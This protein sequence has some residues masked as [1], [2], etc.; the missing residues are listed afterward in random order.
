MCWTLRV[1][2]F[3]F[4]SKMEY[5]C[6]DRVESYVCMVQNQKSNHQI[7]T[8]GLC[9]N[10]FSHIVT[11]IV[12]A[13]IFVHRVAS[14]GSQIHV[15]QHLSNCRQNI[16]HLNRLRPHFGH[17]GRPSPQVFGPHET[18]HAEK[19]TSVEQLSAMKSV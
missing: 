6:K 8:H 1:S 3:W 13:T 16:R 4:L 15:D 2:K 17:S 7:S 18:R 11:S 9:V 12:L 10:S 14:Y 5:T 19:T